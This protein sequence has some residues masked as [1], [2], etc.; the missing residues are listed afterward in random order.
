MAVFILF[1]L[2]ASSPFYISDFPIETHERAQ[3]TCTYTHCAERRYD[4]AS[5]FNEALEHSLDSGKNTKVRG[6]CAWVGGC[7]LLLLRR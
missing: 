4:L 7:K 5:E 6:V 3:C 2:T 1:I